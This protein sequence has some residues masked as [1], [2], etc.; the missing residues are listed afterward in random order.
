MSVTAGNMA[1]YSGDQQ[2][3]Q[4]F[5]QDKEILH[6]HYINTNNKIFN[7]LKGGQDNQGSENQRNVCLKA[8]LGPESKIR[9]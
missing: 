9:I 1:K 6:P 5:I 8:A 2:N 7:V 3:D 4:K